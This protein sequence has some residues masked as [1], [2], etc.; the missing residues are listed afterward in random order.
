P[1][2]NSRIT[3]ICHSGESRNSAKTIIYWM[4]F[5]NGMTTKELREFNNEVQ[6]CWMG[7]KRRAALACLLLQPPSQRSTHATLHAAHP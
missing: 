6:L 5:F 7:W 4:P 2:N 3:L 1:L